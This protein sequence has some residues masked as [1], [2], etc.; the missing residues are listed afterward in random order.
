MSTFIQMT[1]A[2]I[3]GCEETTDS[4]SKESL[5]AYMKVLSIHSILIEKSKKMV[6][7]VLSEKESIEIL[8][9]I[10]QANCHVIA[11]AYVDLLVM[12]GH[13]VTLCHGIIPGVTDK[14]TG[15]MCEHSWI[16]TS[17]GS[18]IEAWPIGAL[19]ACPLIYPKGSLR[20][21]FGANLYIKK[22]STEKV[23]LSDPKIP[24]RIKMLKDLILS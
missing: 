19:F 13:D 18:I 6:G 16:E 22:D 24:S 15:N 4:V 21:P 2:G 9:L 14:G 20:S 12:D 23:V 11:S 17:D 10:P 7:D 1:I 3:E 5:D 8:N